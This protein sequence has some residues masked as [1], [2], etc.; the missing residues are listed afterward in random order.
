MEPKTAESLRLAAADVLA[1]DRR[2][3]RT[4]LRRAV[5]LDPSLMVRLR[6]AD[7]V[8]R[9][10][11]FKDAETLVRA[12]RQAKTDDERAALLVSL[13]RSRHPST[14]P[15][16]RRW[17]TDPLAPTAVRAGAWMGLAHSLRHSPEA[18]LARLPRGIAFGYLPTQLLALADSQR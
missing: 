6:A 7:G 4:L 14:A 8:A 1:L 15:I 17:C 12:V 18:P 2:S 9:H 13:G 10:G 16:L 3:D 5:H 11:R